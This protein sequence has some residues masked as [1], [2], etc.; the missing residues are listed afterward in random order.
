MEP[1]KRRIA[2]QFKRYNDH[3]LQVMNSFYSSCPAHQN[4]VRNVMLHERYKHKNKYK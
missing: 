2:D 3:L 1:I 4:A